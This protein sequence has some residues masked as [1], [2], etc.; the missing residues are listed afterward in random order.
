MI[1]FR[2]AE[3][4][5][6]NSILNLNN[7]LCKFEMDEGFDNYIKDWSLSDE[8]RE[9]FRWLNNMNDEELSQ[10]LDISTYK[11]KQITSGDCNL[12][13]NELCEIMVK[14]NSF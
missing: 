12:D 4:S 7:D 5:D 2:K 3:I 8:S 6:I 9:Y 10:F 13:M 14:I 11:L 1:N